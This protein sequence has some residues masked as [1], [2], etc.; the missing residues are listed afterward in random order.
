MEDAI[1]IVDDEATIRDGV[2]LALAGEYRVQSFAD[3]ESA[4]AAAAEEMPDLVLLDVGLPGMSGIDALERL[5]TMDGDLLVVMI[6]AYEDVATVVAAMKRGAYDYV[7]KP[8]QMASLAAT[9]ERA[10]GSIRLR[11]EVRL[12][13][14]KSLRDQV[15]CCIG[16][17]EA[18]QDMM[19]FV[20][21]VARSPDTPVLIV[22]ETGTGKELVASA[23]HYRSP[24]FA[25]P[26]VA[27]NCA[28]LPRELL[29]SELFGYEKG[30]FSGASPQGK[31]GLI[32]AA[33]GGT[34]FLD[35]IGDLSLEA[36]A[37][38]LRFLES[39]EFFR[40]GG[41]EVVRVR[42]RIVSAT[43][44]HLEELI[45]GGRF[46]RDLFFRLGVVRVR[47]P[48]LAERPEDIL[49]LARYF[50]DHFN[51]KFDKAL[52][53]FAPGAEERLLTHRWGGNVRE[54]RNLIE[55][56]T[57]VGRGEVLTAADLGFAPE[58]GPVAVGAAA[59][60]GLFACLP[61]LTREGLDLEATLR[62]V[63]SVYCQQALHL[64]EGNESQAA[65]LLRLNHHT[66]RYRRKRLAV[67]ASQEGDA[68]G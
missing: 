31:K 24:N 1:F 68:A 6:T 45:A 33:A 57:L 29:E 54:L 13:Q 17:S 51:R 44:Q 11:R 35:E 27:V 48:A 55:R 46:R 60:A 63:E 22:G 39:G 9:V 59:P 12:L 23:I 21:T 20:A 30:A 28:A 65:R 26:F 5:R 32:E 47:V 3:A 16:E 36:Q 15:P 52:R 4:L 64:A 25:G 61:P 14:E 42:T 37:K 8:L 7:V 19:E 10:L 50:L 41:T 38:L 2:A 40:V 62:A 53:G 43:N 34:L 18:L 66:F 49:P 67:P 58:S 56:G